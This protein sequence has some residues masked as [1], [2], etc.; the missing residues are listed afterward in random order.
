MTDLEETPPT[1]EEIASMYATMLDS[2]TA[3]SNVIAEAPDE[4]PEQRER[5]ER[6]V[7]HLKMMKAKPFWTSEDFTS[8]DAA[9]SSGESYL[10]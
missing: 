10:A 3:I 6:N 8:I 4:W 1:A 7:D 9:I 5:A 2:V